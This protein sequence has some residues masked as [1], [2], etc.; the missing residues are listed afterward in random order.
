VQQLT[1][2]YEK[3]TAVDGISFS[4]PRGSFFGFLGPNGAG[5]STTIRVLCG[6]LE[7]QYA[8]IEVAGCD[9]RRDV[10]GVKARIGVM[11]E[12]PL[13]Y[14]RLSAREH[15][16]F[17]GQ[18]YGLDKPLAERRSEELLSRLDLTRD[19]DRLIVDYSQ[20]MRKKTALGCALIHD[21]PVIFLDEPFN[22]I[23]TVSSRQIKDL[24][25]ARV[26]AGTTIMFSSHVMEVVEKLCDSVAIIHRGKI[27]LSGGMTELEQQIGYSGLE[28]LFI[29]AV[30][31]DRVEPRGSTA[32]WLD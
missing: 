10:L 2:R 32:D 1:K 12:E 23:D 25:K 4:V 21:P 16:V 3:F 20:G 8:A 26:A 13:L 31:A 24:L 7:A 27:V 9:L 29:R 30:G 18:M 6:L 17:S 19:A 11:L 5:K 14:D 15:L 28:D 22:G